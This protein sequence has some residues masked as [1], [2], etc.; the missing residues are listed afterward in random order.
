MTIST[1]KAIVILQADITG[2]TG[3]TDS[4]MSFAVSGATTLAASDARSITVHG[5]ATTTVTKT[6]LVTG[7]TNGSNTFTAKYRS[8]VTGTFANRILIVHPAN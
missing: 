6:F 2:S 7:L 5:N 4:F 8:T 3:S 1:G